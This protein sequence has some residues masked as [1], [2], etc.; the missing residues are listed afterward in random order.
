MRS[1]QG[2]PR[3]EGEIWMGN[4]TPSMG[5]LTPSSI[6]DLSPSCCGEDLTPSA[7][8]GEDITPQPVVG[9]ISSRQ[10]VV[11]TSLDLVQALKI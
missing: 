3:S 11:G 1:G 4:L 7:S 5:D 9:K 8:S 6:G 2:W 10:P